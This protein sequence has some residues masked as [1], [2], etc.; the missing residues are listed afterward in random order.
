MGV[1]YFFRYITSNYN[2]CVIEKL[3]DKRIIL[4]FDFNGII[5]DAK[6]SLTYT[7]IK[8][9]IVIEYHLI[10]K[11]IEILN[12]KINSIGFE[13]ID[14]IYI[15]IDGVAPMAKMMQ[16]RQ[17]RYK[18]VKE[19]ELLQNLNKEYNI[20]SDKIVWD[21][22]AIT[23][24]TKFME[25]LN[26][27]LEF[28]RTRMTEIF[29]NMEIIIDNSDTPGEGEHKLLQHMNVNKDIHKDKN[30]VIYGLDADLIILTML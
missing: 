10:E 27:A 30:K 18:S 21:T 6:A 3:N 7:N 12:N 11:V 23:P 29:P 20:T 24:G 15:A 8:K 25:R 17:R 14:T 4:Y 28:Y 1:P 22:N 9:K 16:Q 2:N 5:Y 19:S 13:R 26:D